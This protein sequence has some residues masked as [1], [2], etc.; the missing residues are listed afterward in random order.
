MAHK[1]TS[2]P[3][4]RELLDNDASGDVD[5]YYELSIQNDDGEPFLLKVPC[6][7]IKSVQLFVNQQGDYYRPPTYERVI[8]DQFT[9]MPQIPYGT[10]GFFLYGIKLKFATTDNEK[11]LPKLIIQYINVCRCFVQEYSKEFMMRAKMKFKIVK[12]KILPGRFDFPNADDANEYIDSIKGLPC[13]RFTT[14]NCKKLTRKVASLTQGEYKGR[15]ELIKKIDDCFDINERCKAD[16]AGGILYIKLRYKPKEGKDCQISMKEIEPYLL[17]TRC[18]L[19]RVGDFSSDRPDADSMAGILMTDSIFKMSEPDDAHGVFGGSGG[20][21]FS[22][23][24][25]RDRVSSDS[26]DTSDL[27]ES[28]GLVSESDKE[29][30]NE[31]QRKERRKKRRKLRRIFGTEEDWGSVDEDEDDEGGGGGGGG[32]WCE[33]CKKTFS[34]PEG[35]PACK[36]GGGG[37]FIQSVIK[38]NPETSDQ[39]R[40]PRK[41]SVQDH[42]IFIF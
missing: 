37:T 3:S 30:L 27:D 38:R 13:K 6:G 35:C 23:S 1:R 22:D 41:K 14:Y 10:K 25:K 2:P 21:L 42:K 33:K 16:P 40:E 34:N 9:H 11:E 31:R 28:S 19:G 4:I 26:S 32:G 20:D 36:F 15:K 24:K 39:K 5:Y 12:I 17:E 8:R 7:F 29:D 18:L